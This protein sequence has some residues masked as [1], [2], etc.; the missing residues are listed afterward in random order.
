MIKQII[1]EVI[2]SNI[3]QVVVLTSTTL[4]ML[5]VI[6]S[7]HFVV[8]AR[9]KNLKNCYIVF[10]CVHMLLLIYVLAQFENPFTI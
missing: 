7:S 9:W 2:I 4:H 6:T 3:W 8:I 1:G 10:I 5:D